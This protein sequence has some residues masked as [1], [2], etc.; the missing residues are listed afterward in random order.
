MTPSR[1]RQIAEQS[2]R[3]ARRGQLECTSVALDLE[4]AQEADL[5]RG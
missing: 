5:E 3:L 2:A 4:R 1:S